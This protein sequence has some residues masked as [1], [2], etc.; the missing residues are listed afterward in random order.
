MRNSLSITL[1]D[2]LRR[3]NVRPRLDALAGS[4]GFPAAQIAGR[5]L[6][7]GLRAIEE[8]WH[9][10]FP[11]SDSTSPAAPSAPTH[12]PAETEH[13]STRDVGSCTAPHAANMQHTA[14]PDTTAHAPASPL[15]AQAD[16]AQP[17][18]ADTRTPHDRS[19][20]PE[21]APH[22]EASDE[23]APTQPAPSGGVSTREAAQALGHGSEA[24]LRQH[25][26]RHPELRRFARKSGR[27]L[28]W[29][30][31]GLCAEYRRL[32]FALKGQPLDEQQAQSLGPAE[33]PPT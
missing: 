12:R 4:T 13:A 2:P 8:D 24:A 30:L 17:V 5:A 21:H 7:I 15:A 20:Q 18:D 22:P 1:T 23:P 19:A 29:D 32:G 6:V 33:A 28:I 16:P 9:R 3:E 27:A 25:V 26:Q 14:D 11:A 31:G 10:L